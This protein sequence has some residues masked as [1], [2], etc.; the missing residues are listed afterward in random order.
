MLLRRIA[1]TDLD[2]AAGIL[3]HQKQHAEPVRT[4]CIDAPQGACK[5]PDRPG[6]IRLVLPGKLP[7]IHG[8]V[9]DQEFEGTQPLAFTM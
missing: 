8:R 7:Q 5:Q 4:L 6:Q 9:D 2:K 3:G 1:V